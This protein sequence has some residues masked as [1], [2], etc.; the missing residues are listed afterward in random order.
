MAKSY[1]SH[2]AL[3]ASFQAGH[4]T[5]KYGRGEWQG[6]YGGIWQEVPELAVRR[7]LHTSM[8]SDCPDLTNND[9]SSVLALLKAQVFV[10]DREWD[11][12]P[13]LIA[14]DDG[15]LDLNT[16][17]FGPHS[18]EYYLT[19]KLPF[20]Y[21]P[22]ARSKTWDKFLEETAPDAREFLQEF[23]GYCLTTSTR[24]ELAIWL[25]GPPG[26]GKS[27]FVEG[28]LAM[29]G[30]RSCILGLSDIESSPFGLTNLPG[31]TLA[32]STEQPS[33]YL[34]SPHL[35][36]AIISGEPINVNRKYRD[37]I[38]LTPRCKLLWA[39]NELPR[40]DER[41]SGLFRRIKVVRFEAIPIERR[42][43]RVKEDIQQSG[44]AIANWAL[45][46]MARLTSR[47]RF[48]VPASVEEATEQYRVTNDIPQV[49]IEECCE[50]GDYTIQSS[51]LFVAYTK[52]C[53]VNKH[54]PMSST[55]F[56]DEMIRLGFTKFKVSNMFWRGLRVKDGISAILD[57]YI[58]GGD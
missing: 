4:P 43:P 21:D 16:G 5:L 8:L 2:S 45:E 23:A 31:K 20:R 50:Q 48:I 35:L 6:T 38:T 9:I 33:H 44:M 28:M 25:Y 56:S 22:K 52:W 39:M 36:N 57:D 53:E 13:E 12:R 54:K 17:E 26:G 32:I 30:S 55:R 29:L 14:F 47:G 58:N 1:K 27:T 46:G 42:N 34:K 10:P 3:C 40:V 7:S 37:M 41:G 51:E 19:S 15:V 11:N 49:F 24:Y 18:P